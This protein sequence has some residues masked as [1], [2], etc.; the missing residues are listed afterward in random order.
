MPWGRP[1]CISTL[2]CSGE[3]PLACPH[4]GDP[5]D[6]LSPGEAVAPMWLPQMCRAGGEA[7][8]SVWDT[9]RSKEGA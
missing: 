2:G 3:G 7:H 8:P 4:V 1:G 9:L 6:P 5:P